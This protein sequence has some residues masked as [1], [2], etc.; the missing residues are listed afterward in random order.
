MTKAATRSIEPPFTFDTKV[1]RSTMSG[2]LNDTPVIVQ[3][4]GTFSGKTFGVLLS[5]YLCASMAKEPV[6]ISIV[7]CTLP[8]LK[9][10]ALRDFVGIC[11]ELGGIESWN[12]TENTF[13]IGRATIEFFP[14]DNNDKVRGG[15]RDYLFIN[16]GNLI[17]YERARQLMLR[18]KATAIIDYNPVSAFWVHA[19]ILNRPDIL[20]KRTTWKDNPS[21]PE[22]VIKDLARLKETD[23][24]MYQV[25]AEGRTG[26]VQG[27]IFTNV[28]YAAD[29]FPKAA[30]RRSYG[31]D[32]GFSNDPTALVRFGTLSG[33]IHVEELIY[34]TGLTN[35]DIARKLKD[36]RISR[37]EE[38][39]ADSAEPK[40]IATLR[41]A[42][43]NVRP[44]VKGPDSIRAGIALLKSWPIVVHTPCAN[45]RREFDNYR[46]KED[47]EG[48]YTARPI[49]DHNHALDALRYIASAKL[50]PPKFRIL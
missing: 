10:G 22:K 23:P 28:E 30:Q 42:G 31:L 3:Q 9:R 4:G 34:E 19:K 24:M 49:D 20:F 2:L 32:F 12:K 21:T 13:T 15:K 48:N 44:S 35:A 1:V 5:I 36:M 47:N 41:R 40:S 14:A 38:I 29:P 33:K 26:R 7:G 39:I 43:Y 37:S 25:Y 6:V 27:V 16:E 18:T 50:R 46:W 11:E 8:H 17:N 45:L